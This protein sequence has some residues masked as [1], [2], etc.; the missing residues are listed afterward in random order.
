[1]VRHP[2]FPMLFS[3][4]KVGSIEVPNRIVFSA[5]L[6]NLAE[7]NL[8]GPSLIQYYEER[9]K[10]GVGLII[11]EEQSVHPTDHAYQRLIRAFDERVI[12]SYHRLT[13][14]IHRYGVP[15]IAQINHNG[16][17]ASSVYTRLPVLAPAPVADPLFPAFARVQESCALIADAW[18]ARRLR[19]HVER[20]I[21]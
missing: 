15:I 5:H 7:D 12:P 1:M 19:G 13:S 18:E 3:P 14:R 11:T 6:T 17:Q 8:P 9:A 2:Q 16:G 10:G 4:L 21:P 20:E